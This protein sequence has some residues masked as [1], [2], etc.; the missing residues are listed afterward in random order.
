MQLATQAVLTDL[1][2]LSIFSLVLALAAFGWI[3]REHPHLG[4]ET[5]GNVWTGPF[6]LSDLLIGGLL[7]LFFGSLV[8]AS[9][10]ESPQVEDIS[11]ALLIVD[12]LLWLCIAGGLIASLAFRG[13]RL[14]E[15]L[16]LKRKRWGGTL[17]WGLLAAVA[18]WAAAIVA[19]WFGQRLLFQQAWGEQEVQP[20]VE[21]LRDSDSLGLLSLLFLSVCILAPLCEEAVF[22]G[23]L[24]PAIK[25]FSDRFFAAIFTS[26]LFGLIHGNV[27]LVL[28]LFALALV[29]TLSY[30]LSGSL[31]VPVVGHAA[32]NGVTFFSEVLR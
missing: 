25:R 21:F 2:V 9:G 8:S 1:F 27:T 26:L 20:L 10:A 23:F 12:R 7:L 5:Q 28:P 19:I 3:R 16:G 31:W 32:F 22:R 30:E 29:L 11:P 15:I 14:D 13:E 4:W 18:G 6:Q 17:V 24:Y